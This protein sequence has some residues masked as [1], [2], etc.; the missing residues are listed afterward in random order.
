MR[1]PGH[2][3]NPAT[4]NRTRD[5][6]IYSQMLYQLSYRRLMGLPTDS[7]ESGLRVTVGRTGR[8]GR[9]VRV[10]RGRVCCGLLFCTKE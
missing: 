7:V 9:S 6:L 10:H 5:H 3:K 4:R 1:D 2:G 8:T